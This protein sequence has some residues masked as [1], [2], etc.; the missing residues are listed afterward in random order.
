M[1]HYIYKTTSQ[2]GKYYIGRHSTKNLEDGYL[3]SGKWV[4]GITDKTTL[5]KEILEFFDSFEELK[6]AESRYIS[7]NIGREG[8]MNFNNSSV[9][10]ASGLLNPAHSKEE[11]ERRSIRASGEN[12]PMKNPEVAAKAATSQRGKIPVN[13]GV[14]MT[15]E[16][17]RKVSEGRTGCK[18]SEE[19]K[20]K[21]SESR[22]KQYEEGS[23]EV[24][25]F[26]GFAHS[27]DTKEQMRKMA[28][29][30]PKFNCPHCGKDADLGNFNRWH[31]DKCKMKTTEELGL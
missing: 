14:P 3:G 9:G 18:Y 24:P 15:P 10:F 19:G 11:R 31:G 26:A 29:D 13:K 17:K 8:C 22:K 1:Y 7:E 16:Q 2:S 4:R 23:R 6:D 27:E 12:N 21:L 5:T 30:R 25:S 28:L 20:R